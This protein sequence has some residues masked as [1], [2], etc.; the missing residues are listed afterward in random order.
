MTTDRTTK[1]QRVTRH[2]HTAV[3]RAIEEEVVK[4]AAARASYR[5]EGRAHLL[6]AMTTGTSTMVATA[7]L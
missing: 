1:N 5:D 7:C 3:W 2:R 6:A 4:V